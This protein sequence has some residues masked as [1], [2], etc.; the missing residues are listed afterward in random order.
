MKDDKSFTEQARRALDRHAEALDEATA[1]RLAAMRRNALQAR[2]R[3]AP[4]LPV[5]A[6]SALAASVLTVALLLQRDDSLPVGDPELLDIVASSED[7]E[8]IEELDFYQWLDS[9]ESSG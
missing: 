7:A 8:L 2:P 9:V 4:W 3:R 5:A 1:A 6:V